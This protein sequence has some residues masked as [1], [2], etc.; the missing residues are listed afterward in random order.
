[1]S[2]GGEEKAVRI[3]DIRE[4]LIEYKRGTLSMMHHRTGQ[5]KYFY[6][7]TVRY[8]KYCDEFDLTFNDSFSE[9][10]PQGL[11]TNS[12]TQEQE[13]HTDLGNN[14]KKF[15]IYRSVVMS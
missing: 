8:S 15:L 10:P 6:S 14:Q 5:I 3:E 9:H 12:P 7:C 11:K 4:R 2:F 13:D 1:M